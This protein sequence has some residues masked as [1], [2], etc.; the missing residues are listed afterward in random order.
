MPDQLTRHG[1]AMLEQPL[2]FNMWRAPLDNDRPLVARWQYEGLEHAGMKV[3]RCDWEQP[4]EG[5]VVVTTE[6]SLGLY[7]RKPIVRGV[8][9]WLFDAQGAVTV[10][11][12]VQVKEEIDFL[13]RFGLQ[14][15]MPAVMN[16]VDY[17]GYGPHES[18]VDKRQSVRKGRY[19]QRVEE[20]GEP[21][22]MPQENGSR[23]GTEWAIVSNEL[24]MGLL[25]DGTEPFSLNAS[26][27]L[28]Q[29]LT[30]AKHT[31]ELQQRKE[32]IVQLDYKMS[33]VG[34]HSCGPK[35]MDKYQLKEKQFD[36]QFT[37]RP[38]FKED[39]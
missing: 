25:L 28:P 16:T 35:L 20:M 34:S 36:F 39:E 3:Y 19:V 24:G 22:I 8:A 15:R 30:A 18:Y 2:S 32:T 31:Y 1:V 4:A 12:S 7:T 27:Y 37:L 6:F 11:A 33:G 9:Q 21:Y 5:E 38:V 26:R 13:P 23:W 29:D 17:V 10:K 14:L